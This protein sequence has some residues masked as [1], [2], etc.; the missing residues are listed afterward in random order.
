[1]FWA[2]IPTRRQLPPT[3][4][5]RF[6]PRLE[7]LE[8]RT[9][10][11]A[12]LQEEYVLELMNRLRTNPQAELPL[13]LNSTDPDV[14]NAL[15]YFHVDRSVLA[16]QWASLT[17]VPPVAWNDT[18]AGTAL[19]HTQLM[20]KDDQQ[21]HQLPGEP[22]PDVR[23][24]NAGYNF[25]DFGENIFAS[26]TSLFDAHAAFAIDWGSTSTGIQNPP[27][28][29]ENLMNPVFRDVGI[30]LANVLPGNQHTGPLLITEDF[31]RLLNPGNPWLVGAVFADA[32]G[33]GFYSQ[34][35][36]LAGVSVSVSGAGGTFTTT[37][38]AAGGYQLKLPAGTYTVTFSGGGLALPVTRSVTVAADN[39]LLNVNASAGGTLQFSAPTYTATEG[40]AGATITVTRTGGGNGTFTVHYATSNGTAH[41]GTDYTATSGTL[42]FNPGVTSKT[43]TIPILNDGVADGNETV[44]LTL[45]G[46]TG[47][48]ALGSPSAAVLTITEFPTSSVNPLPAF[49]P[50][51]N[52]TVSWSGSGS[53]A[54]ASYDVFVSDNGGPFTAFRTGTTQTSATFTGQDGHTYGFYS[55]ATDT[56]GHVQPTP[57]GAQATTLVDLSPPTSSVNPLPATTNAAAVTLSWTGSDGPAGSGVAGYDVFVSDNG[58]AF[59]AFLTGTTQTSATFVGVSGHAYAFYSVATDRAGHV[60]PTPSGA[61]ATTLFLVP[62]VP[63]PPAPPPV[64]GITAQLVPLRVGKKKRLMVEVHF[65]DTGALKGEVP[66]PFQKPAFRDIQVSVRDGNGD[67]VADEVVL[68]ARKGKRTL[69]LVF[70]G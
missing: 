50:S 7:A 54:I 58:G 57:A 19:A 37:T 65:A 6:A 28:H 64:V 56:G 11:D 27:G 31:G 33:D 5:R 52:F 20:N 55:V 13:L 25:S 47:G 21:A 3:A 9:L 41:A 42:T 68:T 44:N 12:G 59:T 32:D 15:S 24:E 16:Q 69:S 34:G 23:I 14:Q 48:A 4:R 60:Q 29:R 10:L 63:P 17:P 36:G 70:L 40:G 22:A 66:S 18:L 26:A 39:V 53:P 2:L 61:Q 43:F 49:T 62:V 8:D 35:E 30:G 1:M 38:S 67:G 45:S 46:P 51:A